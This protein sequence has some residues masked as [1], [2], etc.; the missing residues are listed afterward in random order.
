MLNDRVLRLRSIRRARIVV[1][2]RTHIVEVGAQRDTKHKGVAALV[3]EVN[4]GPIGDAVNGAD[5]KLALLF[6]LA[7]KIFGV[8][9]TFVF[10]LQAQRLPRRLV[11]HAAK[12]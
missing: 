8:V 6:D 11:F 4:V 1:I 2:R 5:V 3:A 9:I 10:Q 12:Q 7:R